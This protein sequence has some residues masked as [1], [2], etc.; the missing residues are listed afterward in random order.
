MRS[1]KANLRGELKLTLSGCALALCLFAMT[2]CL[3]NAQRADR[4]MQ[5]GQYEDALTLYEEAIEGGS[6]DPEVFFRAA[7]CASKLGSFGDA[8][9]HFSRSLRYGGGPDVARALA[10]LYIQTSNY[11]QAVRVLQV[12][13]NDERVNAQPI[14]NNLGTALMYAGEVLDAESYLLI[15]QQMDPKDP[16]PYV[17]LG[18]LYDRY[19]RRP[20]LALDFY[21]CYLELIPTKRV[22]QERSVK[23]R[24][25]ELQERERHQPSKH[26]VCGQ[27]YKAPEPSVSSNEALQALKAQ[28][29]AEDAL[30]PPKPQEPIELVPDSSPQDPSKTDKTDKTAPNK[31]VDPV[32]VQV[33]SGGELPPEPIKVADAQSAAD[34]A[35]DRT[36][37]KARQQFSQKQYQ[38]VVSTLELLSPEQLKASDALLMGR[39]L[40]ALE[41]QDQALVWF[42]LALQRQ[43]DPIYLQ[44][45]LE[46]LIAQ[47]Q[48]TEASKLCKKYQA[49]EQMAPALSMCPR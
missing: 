36:R 43:E 6:R 27:P 31:Q 2:G 39:A 19:M 37:Q 40:R 38:D 12:L 4:A 35:L 26:V 13:L 20:S 30:N 14:Y 3:T 9:R 48:N 7:T 16:F 25:Y 49:N 28:A 5:A 34:A 46:L 41:R 33:E 23:L 45:L 17:N 44:A 10:Q 8:E 1:L 42:K 29:K 18:L 24:I 32:K 22:Q 15:A 11:A 21:A 47:K